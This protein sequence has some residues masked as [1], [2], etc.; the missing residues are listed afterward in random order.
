MEEKQDIGEEKEDR[1]KGSHDKMF[2][3]DVSP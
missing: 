2:L 3:I 1:D